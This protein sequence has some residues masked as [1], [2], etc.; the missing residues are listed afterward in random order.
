MIDVLRGDG[1]NFTITCFCRGVEFKAASVTYVT[2]GILGLFQRFLNAIRIYVAPKFNARI[3][4]I[5][6]YE[7]FCLI[8]LLAF[9]IGKP[10]D[11]AHVWD[12]CPRLISL[13]KRR[14]VF[15]V[16][17]VPIAPTTY[18]ERMISHFN[19]DF[20]TANQRI[21]TFEIQ[22]YHMAD[23]VIAPSIFVK[24]E[25]ILAGVDKNKIVVV[26]FGVDFS[27]G[28]NL[29]QRSIEFTG[30]TH[31]KFCFFGLIN[32]R[33]GVHDLLQVWKRRDFR[34][35]SLYLCGRIYPDI[36]AEVAA[37]SAS[38]I[39]NIYTPGFVDPFTAMT[40]YD[41]FVFPSWMEGSSKAVFE[42]MSMGLPCIVTHSSGS[43]VRDGIDGFVIDAGDRVALFEKMLWFKK[44]R[45]RGIQMGESARE[46]AS[47]YTWKRYS[48]NVI[49][50]Y[51][52]H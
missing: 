40:D 36:R 3:I 29:R 33:K 15:V 30:S 39:D 31:L 26:N 12:S 14:G 8:R 42:A 50:T 2:L 21:K 19:V 27:S 25:L 49:S 11:I 17:D 10:G 35:D 6:I 43:I 16:V 24:N 46:R 7:W 1:N 45:S 13:L 51:G 41:V 47:Q 52:V 22:S 23:V 38:G 9:S 20:L 34:E 4:D 18:C 44:N 32:K 28:A 48:E 5:G 37:L